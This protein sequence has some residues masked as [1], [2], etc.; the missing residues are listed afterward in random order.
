V[1]SMLMAD[2]GIVALDDDLS[3]TLKLH[4]AEMANI[5]RCPRRGTGIVF[6][7]R[8]NLGHVF[9]SI[10]PGGCDRR[11]LIAAR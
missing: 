4:P 8:Q 9:T 5:R 10:D 2:I 3:A 11:R 7:Y 6:S 1:R